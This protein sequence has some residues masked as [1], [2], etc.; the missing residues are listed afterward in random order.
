MI[1]CLIGPSACGKSTLAQSMQKEIENSVII[2]RDK[3]R[4]ML[5]GYTERTMPA[6][7]QAGK[8]VI[9]AS[10][11][12]VSQVQ[13]T[14]I[15]NALENG[16]TVILDNTHLKMSYI[17]RLKKFGVPIRFVPVVL[18]F[19]TAILRDMGRDRQV[20]ENIIRK[21]FEE[22]EHLRKVFD[23]KPYEPEPVVP[24]TQDHALP[25]AYIFDIDGTLAHNDGHRSPYD[26]SKVGG[27]APREWVV[28]VLQ[29]IR[30]AGYPTIIVSGRDS[31]CHDSTE[32]WLIDNHIFCE[33]LHMRPH[34]DTRKDSVIK[35]EIFRDIAKR[36]YI[37][38]IFDD[39]K[40]VI[41]HSRK[42]GLNVF[43]VANHKF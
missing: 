42:L 10:E 23:F 3:L 8:D 12:L 28:S 20:G 18:D 38:A 41:D 4:E 34:G 37:V 14:L 5:F 21:Q 25:G 39:R 9:K 11:E 13:D 17:H 35:E 22:Y 19:N 33:S 43:D 40:R 26:Y 7:Y 15:E 16:K 29:L 27:D 32:K 2:G 1:Y 31:I 24:I 30:S 36:Y 6:Y